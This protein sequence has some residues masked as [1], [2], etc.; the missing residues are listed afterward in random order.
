VGGIL[1][2]GARRAGRTGADADPDTHPDDAFA[3]SDPE[4][5]ADAEP[6][7]EPVAVTDADRADAVAD[8]VGDAD[9]AERAA[10]SADGLTDTAVGLADA[11]ADRYADAATSDGHPDTDAERHAD[12]ATSERHPDAERHT[13]TVGF[14]VG[15]RV[16]D[17][18]GATARDETGPSMP[19]R[20][21]DQRHSPAS[22]DFTAH[23]ARVPGPV[24]TPVSRAGDYPLSRCYGTVGQV[25]CGAGADRRSREV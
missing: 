6:I 8:P 19:G 21:C 24:R 9:L 10:E 2:R 18:L 11:D 13:H 20:P 3:D 16:A 22:W 14:V 23:S 4:A 7:A 17:T 1:L 12:A 5:Q 25:G 15:F